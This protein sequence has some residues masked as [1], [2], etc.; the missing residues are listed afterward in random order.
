M[1]LGPSVTRRLVHDVTL[2]RGV[3][4]E[5]TAESQLL[6]ALTPRERAVFDLLAKGLPNAEIAGEM[7]VSVETVKSHVAEVLRKLG[8]RDRVQ[9]L[10]FAFENGLAGRG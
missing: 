6:A 7:L 9:V 8:L 2:A 1:L 4:S 5:P 3:P 10:V